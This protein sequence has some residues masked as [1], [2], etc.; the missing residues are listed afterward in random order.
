MNALTYEVSEVKFR[1]QSNDIVKR[2]GYRCFSRCDSLRQI[3]FGPGSKLQEIEAE[4]LHNDG[5]ETIEHF[6][7]NVKL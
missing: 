3:V 7:E 5:L 6:L 4:A 1:C 2:I